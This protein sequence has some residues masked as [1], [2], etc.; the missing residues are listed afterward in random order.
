MLQ[1]KDN[2]R[3]NYIQQE[4]RNTCFANNTLIH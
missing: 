4:A 1:S 2:T 3:L